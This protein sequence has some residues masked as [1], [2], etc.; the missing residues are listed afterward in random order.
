MRLPPLGVWVGRV[1][2]LLGLAVVV[3]A[4]LSANVWALVAAFGGFLV[5]IGLALPSLVRAWLTDAPLSR[6]S[7]FGHLLEL[8]CRSYGARAGW[9][10]GLEEGDVEV[11]SQEPVDAQVRQRGGALV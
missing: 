4:V 3:P 10:V 11:V 2:A 5:G 7:D 6:P 8:M 9:I 1:L